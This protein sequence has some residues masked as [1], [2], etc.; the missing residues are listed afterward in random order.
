M[1]I[2][3]FNERLDARRGDEFAGQ[4][5]SFGHPDKRVW[6]RWYIRRGVI[7]SGHVIARLQWR[8]I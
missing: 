1:P 8:F 6:R 4:A 7:V 3:E 2:Y 5:V